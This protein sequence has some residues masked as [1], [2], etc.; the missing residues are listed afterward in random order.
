MTAAQQYSARVAAVS[1]QIQELRRGQAWTDRWGGSTAERARADPHRALD[2]NLEA[3]ASYIEPEDVLLDVGGGAGR[4]GLPLAL[5]CR[6]LINVD[7]SAGMRRQFEAAASEAGIANA[8]F[9]RAAWPTEDDLQAD[10]QSAI[11]DWRTDRVR[12]RP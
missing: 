10:V 11:G 3:L 8:R 1:H 7:P 6:E 12:P 5:R 9:V 2:A 4:I